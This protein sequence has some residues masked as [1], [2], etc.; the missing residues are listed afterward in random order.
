MNHF[1]TIFV[2]FFIFGLISLGSLILNEAYDWLLL[3]LLFWVIVSGLGISV[4]YHR[5][6]AHKA[7]KVPKWFEYVCTYLGALGIQG[8]SISWVAIH[9]GYHH[10]HADTIKDFHTPRKGL[11]HA[12]AG[13]FNDSTPTLRVAYAGKL[14]RD[15]FHLFLHNYYIAVVI[16]S[17][18][19]IYVLFGWKT[20]LYGYGI[21]MLISLM[22]ENTINVLCHIKKLGYRNFNTRDDSVNIPILGLL[23]WGQ[24]W[25]NN[26]HENPHK[27][28]FGH[29][30]WE[31]DL[32]M[33]FYPLLIVVG[34]ENAKD[35]HI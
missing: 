21:A 2:P 18:I 7:F 1:K 26:H 28:N 5:I 33:I 20:L 11:W 4:G 13:W 15:K 24:G 27:F 35:K 8:S 19:I 10:P 23:C 6:L 14:L 17:C 22:Q 31:V 12:F 25:H 34:K 29:Y 3:S 30:W 9:R 16:I 32:T